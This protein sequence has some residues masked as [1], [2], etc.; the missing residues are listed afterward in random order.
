[1]DY[2]HVPTINII[3]PKLVAS[4]KPHSNNLQNQWLSNDIINLFSGR[5]VSHERLFTR[6]M[7]Q[8]YSTVNR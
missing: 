1:M 3:F 5:D 6:D 8:S 2:L 7:H 4:V